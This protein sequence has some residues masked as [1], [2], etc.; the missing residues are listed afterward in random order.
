MREGRL[1]PATRRSDSK[2]AST[3]QEVLDIG[4][5]VVQTPIVK[6]LRVFTWFEAAPRTKKILLSPGTRVENLFALN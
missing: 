3:H 6:E 2:S 5:A 1:F 4:A